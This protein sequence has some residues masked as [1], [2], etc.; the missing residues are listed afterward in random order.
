M[1]YSCVAVVSLAAVYPGTL[2]PV[3]IL[4]GHQ[5]H[6]G[7]KQS[8]KRMLVCTVHTV[9]KTESLAVLGT[10]HPF[11]DNTMNMDYH[12]VLTTYVLVPTWLMLFV[13]AS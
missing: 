7:K 8:T 2:V 4:P 10:A 6:D 13:V 12:T 5:H 11:E 1:W 3:P 9:Y